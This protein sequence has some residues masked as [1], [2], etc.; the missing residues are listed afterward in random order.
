MFISNTSCLSAEPA[1]MK[2][3][4][5]P[6]LNGQHIGA[7]HDIRPT[8]SGGALGVGGDPSQGGAPLPARLCLP[9]SRGAA[10]GFPGASRVEDSFP[11]C[12]GKKPTIAL[13]HLSDAPC[14]S[15]STQQQGHGPFCPDGGGGAL[16][17]WLVRPGT[18]SSTSQCWF[19]CLFAF[20]GHTRGLWRFPGQGSNRSCS[21]RPTPQPQQSGIR[22][23]SATYPAVHGNTGPLTHG[24]SPGVEPVSSWIRAG[25]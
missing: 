3:R 11:V 13:P 14:G 1:L 4:P 18:A 22:A 12:L 20:Q 7:A 9:L 15:R 2:A 10:P 25:L 5:E 19:V 6:C 21:C 17:V 24:A 23:A 16:G 8:Q